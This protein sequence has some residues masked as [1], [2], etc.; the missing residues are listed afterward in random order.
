MLF[1]A[2]FQGCASVNSAWA[3]RYESE[4][5]VGAGPKADMAR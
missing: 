1:A 5:R 2:A 3:L 4:Q